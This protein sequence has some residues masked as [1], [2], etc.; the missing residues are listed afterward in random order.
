MCRK[1]RKEPFSH[2][3]YF[4]VTSCGYFHWGR[5]NL[6]TQCLLEP[7]GLRYWLGAGEYF[8]PTKGG[9]DQVIEF[10]QPKGEIKMTF[11]FIT[12]FI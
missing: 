5:I 8:L 11:L 9:N 7:V 1:G 6:V 3:G 4:D 10:K 12:D 2:G